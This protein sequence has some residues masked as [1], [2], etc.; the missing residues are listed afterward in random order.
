MLFPE[1]DVEQCPSTQ[2]ENIKTKVKSRS[3]CPTSV[4]YCLTH[5]L[6]VLQT[7]NDNVCF[8]LFFYI[9]AKC[10]DELYVNFTCNCT[11]ES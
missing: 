2:V 10:G 5:H 4:S 7:C 1:Q 9:M 6:M 11:F 8:V 3:L